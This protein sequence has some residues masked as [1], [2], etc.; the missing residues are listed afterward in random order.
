M[1][2]RVALVVAAFLL[3]T[4]AYA[5]L[6]AGFEVETVAGGLTQPTALAFTEDGRIFVTE[7]AGSVRVIKNGALLPTP[8]ITL[9]D[10]NAYGDRGLLGIAV[11][12]QF[13]L[14]GYLYLLYTYENT[15]GANVAGTKTGRLVRVTVLGDSA[16]EST[17][18]VLLGTVGGTAATPS[19]ENYAVT[20]DCIPSDSPSHS[21]GGLRFGPDGALYVTLGDGAHFD[22]VDVRAQRA[23]NLDSLAG[24]VLRINTDGTGRA[25]NPFY[26]GTPSANR[27]KVYA[28]GV[29]NAYK[30]NFRPS[31]SALYIGD[32]GWDS[33]EEVN[34]VTPGANFGWPCREGNGQN[35][36]LCDVSPRTDPM[37]TYPHNAAGAGAVAGGAFPTV[38]P[39]DY[40]DSYFFGDYAQNWIKRIVVDA[41]DQFV[42]VED[43]MDASDNTQ[44][45]VAIDRGPEGLL[46]FISIYTGELKRIVYTTGNRQPIAVLSAT[47]TNGLA[48]LTVSFSATG[49]SDPDGHPLSY[50]WT[51]G[52]G[53][54][55]TGESVTHTY[56]TNGT[57]TAVLTVTDGHGGRSVRSVTVSVGNRA[58]TAVITAPISGALYRPGD[59]VPLSG[60]G[61][62]PED[63]TL[64]S[65]ALAW[66]IILHHNTH[67]HL[68]ETLTGANPS[69]TAP[70][71]EGAT[72]IYTEVRLTVTDSGG[73]THTRSIN[74]YVNTNPT[75][76]GNLV[77]NPSLEDSVP[78]VPGSPLDW[79]RGGW[80]TMTTDY[81]YPAPGYDGAKAARV[82]I[83]SYTSGDAKWMHAPVSV[84]PGTTYTFR[85]FYKSTAPT[86]LLVQH[87][88]GGGAYTYETLN[89]NVP[90]APDWT[91]LTYTFT[92][93]ANGQTAV[94]ALALAQVGTTEIDLFS[95][96]EGAA[97]PP[98]PA[99]TIPPAVSLTEPLVGATVAGSVEVAASAS[100]A[101][102][103]AEVRFFVD[104]ALIAQDGIAPYATVWDT[105]SVADGTHT[106]TAV[107][108]DAAGNTATS[109]QV[110]VAVLN[111]PP[112]PVN[113]IENPSVETASGTAT[114]PEAWMTR[115][116]GTHTAAF[117][118]PATGYNSTRAVELRVT[119]YRSG[120]AAWSFKNVAV[121]PGTAYT[122]SHHYK[123]TAQTRVVA[124][125]KLS[126]G[127]T[128]TVA[129][130]TSVPAST[131]WAQLSYTLT[132]PVNAVSVTVE[133]QLRR[134]G[135]LTTD[136]YALVSNAPPPP[137][138]PP[139]PPASNL[140]VN[141]S[142]DTANGAD[143]LSWVRESYGSHTA[144]FRYPVPGRSGNA[145]EIELTNYADGA[146]YWRPQ[147]VPME[148]GRAY[149]ISG[150]YKGTTITD[151]IGRYTLTDGGEHYFGVAKELPATTT[152]AYFSATFTPPAVATTFTPLYMMTTNGTFALDDLRLTITGYASSTNDL[153]PPSVAITA[154]APNA[155]V[156]GT[157]TVSANSSD[158]VVV[159]GVMFAVD[160]T[161]V[162]PLITAAP[163]TFSW[164]TTGWPDGTH[165]LKATTN[166]ASGNNAFTTI[167]V[168]VDNAG[169]PPPPPT[170]NM[171]LNPSLEDEA[172][173]LPVSWFQGRWGTHNATFTYPVAGQS[174]TKAARVSMTSYSSG[175]AK[176]Y[177]TPRA[178]S[179]GQTLSYRH[180][181]Q[182]TV[183]TTVTAQ[184][185]RTDGTY[186][187]VELDTLPAAPS[188][189]TYTKSLTVPVGVT[190]VTVFHYLAAVGSLTVDAFSLE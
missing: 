173:G 190:E 141:G 132:P 101:G 144:A 104:G 23:Q 102:G 51:F 106:L 5:A 107:A 44:G 96:T 6:P 63:G 127:A 147:P 123:A 48:P 28:Y 50:A 159:T 87:G 78:G 100:D 155:T 184:Y 38:Y 33:W 66:E 27:S 72:D 83:V 157:V 95:I 39:G 156:S 71:H 45:P 18:V 82:S 11:D 24:K 9:T 122:Y 182:A 65:A 47:P 7:K 77:R 120:N 117:T 49:S 4:P 128:S 61:T 90:V 181:F 76:S 10:V 29:R 99:D 160:G 178:V 133:H 85:G 22:Y 37:Y 98:P 115:K 12:P 171:I 36:Y 188:W 67:T 168:T 86:E 153:T 79:S 118:Y 31:T 176:W 136:Q 97:P 40:A 59:M 69:F 124:L 152:W 8:L 89:W 81:V 161:P 175:D 91:P 142:L 32:V 19:C 163:Y 94:V 41:T 108:K 140:I 121:T 135:T 167:T 143:P 129:L 170:T 177:F 75:G 125:Y 17:K 130:A 42:R 74:L 54:S 103:V 52:D 21:V 35:A 56:D 189:T 126:T 149:T 172:A 150:W 1:R 20:D 187:Y 137:P 53:T 154:P 112:P 111:A 93:P 25:D 34:V 16:D 148:Y 14:N 110:F 58:P 80:G 139:P 46:Y 151:L 131:N 174:G 88:V 169:T 162:T 113:L 30:L 186:T 164:N 105:T 158:N 166:D 60:A 26:T 84:T 3:A 145:L 68:L 183:P 13:S 55:D 165:V 146:S 15:P 73:L 138:P 116:Q 62:D 92:T 57:Y 70:D 179:G 180:Y 43:F 64:P 109:T 185:Q 2:I 114:I 134:N 119:Q